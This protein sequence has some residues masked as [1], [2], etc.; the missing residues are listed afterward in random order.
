MKNESIL[1][2]IPKISYTEATPEIDTKEFVKVVESRRSVRVFDGTPIPE[3]VVES[4]LDLALL[5]PNS[6]NL[7]AWEFY[8]VRS[9]ENK[10]ALVKACLSQPAASTAAELFVAVART[11]TWKRHSQQMLAELERSETHVPSSAKAYYQKIVPLA[12]SLGPLSALGL[13]K[14]IVLFFVGI[15]KVVPREPVSKSDMRIWASKSTAL[16]CENLMLAFRAYGYDTCPMEGLDSKRVR[17][18]LH[19]PKDAF[20]VMAISA[21]KR[22]QNGVYGPR[23]RFPKDQFVKRI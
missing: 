11:Q 7:Q 4:C 17:K 13:L 1:S 2:S 9:K 22:A 6:S 10:E 14:R 23:I 18:I 15:S 12:Y 5:A 3:A 16:A 19:L 8:W 20:V 21:G